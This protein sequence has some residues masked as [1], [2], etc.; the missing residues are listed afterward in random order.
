M[1]DYRRRKL[2]REMILFV[3]TLAIALPL[4]ALVVVVLVSLSG[5]FD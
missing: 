1:R 5:G 2:R 3:V 4:G